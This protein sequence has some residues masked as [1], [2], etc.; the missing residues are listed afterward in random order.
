[1]NFKEMKANRKSYLNNLRSKVESQLAPKNSYTDDRFWTL[2]VDE[3]GNGSAIIRF[4]PPVEG[5]ELPYAKYW[6]HSF[7]NESTRQHYIENCLST[8][9]EN[10]PVNEYNNHTWDELTDQQRQDRKRKLNYIANIYVVEDKKNPENEGKVFLFRFGASIFNMIHRAMFPDDEDETPI[11]V[12][13]FWDG[14]NFRLKAINKAGFRNYDTNSKFIAPSP[15]SD[16]DDELEK[17]YKAQYPLAPFTDKNN[18]EQFKSYEQLVERLVRVIPEAE[19]FFNEKL[20]RVKKEKPAPVAE[21]A[22]PKS[23]ESSKMSVDDL[24]ELDI[25]LNDDDFGFDLDDMDDFQD[26]ADL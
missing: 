11:D 7:K 1:M 13:D 26:L 23:A 5:E 4:L 25:D 3:A 6:S 15:L 12:F 19:D 10:D 22:Q 24:D 18:K 9:G 20:G 8:V 16:D 21:A 2:K 17:I 14:A